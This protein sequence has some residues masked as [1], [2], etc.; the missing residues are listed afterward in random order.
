[1][2]PTT[3][4]HIL[5]ISEESVLSKL[6]ELLLHNINSVVELSLCLNH[7]HLN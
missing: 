2:Y 7:K 5:C 4:I 1:M 6:V 3:C